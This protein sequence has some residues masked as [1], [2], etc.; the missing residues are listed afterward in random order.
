MDRNSPRSR[1]V[2]SEKDDA[3]GWI[4]HINE[5]SNLI[6]QMSQMSEEI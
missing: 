6:F 2:H 5:I 4:G 3:Q 1:Q